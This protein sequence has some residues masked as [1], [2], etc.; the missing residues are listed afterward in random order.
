[1]V[2]FVTFFPPIFPACC[3]Y[4]KRKLTQS[5]LIELNHCKESYVYTCG[6]T[7]FPE[8]HSLFSECS[9]EFLH[10]CEELVSPHYYSSRL[11]CALCCY[12]CGAYGDLIPISDEMKRSYQSVHPVCT[13][14]SAEGKKYALEGLDMGKKGLQLKLMYN[15]F[16]FFIRLL[17][18]TLLL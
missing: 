9:P 16:V 3:L 7:I 8:S 1:M 12:C 11:Q 14:C 17:V 15:F 6:G 5:D 2:E 13:M 10:S 4:S 18:Y